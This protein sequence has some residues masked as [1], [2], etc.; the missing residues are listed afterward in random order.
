MV[1]WDLE[2]V[3]GGGVVID[4]IL[5]NKVGIPDRRRIQPVYARHYL[6]L[7]EVAGRLLV[8]P[9]LYARC[10]VMA[11]TMQAVSLVEPC[12]VEPGF[13]IFWLLEKRCVEE[14]RR[15]VL[16]RR[17]IRLFRPGRCCRA[18]V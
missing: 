16:L 18:G 3:D 2:L 11:A 12:Y 17:F 6:S 7:P 8:C 15:G 5:T 10:C 9:S 4:R 14:A 1:I 13:F